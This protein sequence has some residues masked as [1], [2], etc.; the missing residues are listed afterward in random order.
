M[1]S[2]KVENQMIG[3]EFLELYDEGQKEFKG[4]TITGLEVKDK[5]FTG[6][7]LVNVCLQMSELEGCKFEDLSL[8]HI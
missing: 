3:E 7:K 6:L 2:K 5:T 1:E 4:C 8:I